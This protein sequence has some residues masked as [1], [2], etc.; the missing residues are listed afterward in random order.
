[1]DVIHTLGYPPFMPHICQDMGL[2]LAGSAKPPSHPHGSMDCDVRYQWPW[3][4]CHAINMSCEYMG[5]VLQAYGVIN[6]QRCIQSRPQ[7]SQYMGPGLTWSAKLSS[8]PHVYMIFIAMYQ[9]AWMGCHPFIMSYECMGKVP[10]GLDAIH[11]K[12]DP[13]A[14]SYTTYDVGIPRFFRI[15]KTTKPSLWRCGLE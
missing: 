12:G 1:M 11:T 9:G 8:H 3:I 10:Q 13:P 14:R 2:G 5:K 15:Y 6:V 4:C 7:T